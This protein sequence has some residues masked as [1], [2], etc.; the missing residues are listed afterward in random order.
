MVIIEASVSNILINSF[1]KLSSR[2][3]SFFE[4]SLKE[5][6]SGMSSSVL[7][8]KTRSCELKESGV[9]LESKNIRR[10]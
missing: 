10:K 1:M 7:L 9:K 8:F 4:L 6:G 3:N 5:G 2:G